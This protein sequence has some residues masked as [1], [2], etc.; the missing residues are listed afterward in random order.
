MAFSGD[1]SSR[2]STPLPDLMVVSGYPLDDPPPYTVGATAT[3]DSRGDKK[4]TSL[5]V[6]LPVH[7]LS[8]P[9]YDDKGAE[10]SCALSHSDSSY[11]SGEKLISDYRKRPDVAAV[12]VCPKGV[13]ITRKLAVALPQDGAGDDQLYAMAK[14][15]ESNSTLESGTTGNDITEASD[16]VRSAPSGGAFMVVPE[17]AGKYY[18]RLS[19]CSTSTSSDSS[20]SLVWLAT[21]SA[22]ALGRAPASSGSE[23]SVDKDEIKRIHFLKSEVETDNEHWGCS[24]I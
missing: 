8:N 21:K 6:E 4:T 9:C 2:R 13:P 11:G 14:A 22:H 19:V 23:E 1:F 3:G 10:G 24:T 17:L 16:S 15:M 18:S 12:P 5:E 7:S 20:G